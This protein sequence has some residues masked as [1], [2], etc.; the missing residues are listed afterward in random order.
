MP[1]DLAD[2]IDGTPGR[3]V[4]QEMK[5]ELVE[6]EH[7]TRYWWSAALARDRRVLD[8]GC[9]MAYGSALLAD[10]GATTVTGVD[11]AEDVILAARAAVGGRVDLHA[12]DVRSLPFEDDAFDLVVCFEVI[13]HVEEQARV[14][15][16]FRRVLAPGGLLAISSPNREAYVPGNPHHHHEFTPSELEAVLKERWSAVRLQQQHNYVAS[17]VTGEQPE[18]RALSATPLGEETYT[19]ALASDAAIPDIP[20]LVTLAAPV[21]IRQWV[22]RF[23]SQQEVLQRQADLLATARRDAD[24]RREAQKALADAETRL[25]ALPALRERARLAEEAHRDLA[26]RVEAAEQ[27]ADRAEQVVAGLQ[28][29]LSW[30]ITA[31]LRAAKRLR[32]RAR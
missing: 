4:P 15:D 1:I 8:A 32:G 13:E 12:G 30:R 23:E 10:A 2:Y 3:F 24:R 5:G 6:A 18:V 27:R 21:E 19:L 22:E 31:P 9:G 11:L 29:S 25:A 17:S 7:L 14:L 20:G 16:E 28:A 26:E